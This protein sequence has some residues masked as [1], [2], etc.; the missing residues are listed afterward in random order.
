MFSQ[1][2]WCFLV[3]VVCFLCCCWLFFLEGE[4]DWEREGE[5]RGCVYDSM[6][7]CVCVCVCVDAGE[8]RDRV[9]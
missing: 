8:G 9:R 6:C 5:V 2:D 3:V 7:V 1:A 4:G